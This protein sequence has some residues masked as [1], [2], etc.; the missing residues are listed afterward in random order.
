VPEPVK[1]ADGSLTLHSERY[2][3]T[4]HSVHGAVTESQH[5]FLEGAGVIERLSTG[6]NGKHLRI[7]EVGLGL[8]IN[9]L[10]TANAAQQ[11]GTHVDYVGIEFDFP[12]NTY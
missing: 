11:F 6:N 7:L 8:G 1:T 9:A 4:Y 3:Q 12:V 10:L 2:N 5:V